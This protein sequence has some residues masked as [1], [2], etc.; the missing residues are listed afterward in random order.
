MSQTT[1]PT[2]V[3][4]KQTNNNS[5]KPPMQNRLHH[6]PHKFHQKMI[7]NYR[8]MKRSPTQAKVGGSRSLVHTSRS[9][10]LR[11]TGQKRERT[12]YARTSKPVSRSHDLYIKR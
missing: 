1:I 2:M 12:I 6:Q 8:I 11:G 5:N 4:R 9:S 3:T 10:V 7:R